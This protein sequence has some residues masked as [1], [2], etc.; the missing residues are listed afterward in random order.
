MIRKMVKRATCAGAVI[1]KP[2]KGAPEPDPNNAAIESWQSVTNKIDNLDV[3]KME[4]II[5]SNVKYWFAAWV[6][7]IVAIM[8]CVSWI[9]G[10]NGTTWAFSSLVIGGIVG[11]MLGIKISKKEEKEKK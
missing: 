6:I 9:L 11:T 3:S 1:D 10:L 2:D 7:S 5:I 4:Q 8:Q